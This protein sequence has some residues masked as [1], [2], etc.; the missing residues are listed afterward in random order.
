MPEGFPFPLP[1]FL[2]GGGGE[3]TPYPGLGALIDE[4]MR[5][6]AARAA[7]DQPSPAPPAPTTDIDTSPTLPAP[8]VP[9]PNIDVP[10]PPELPG[11]VID[12]EAPPPLPMTNAENYPYNIYV[13]P[14]GGTTA[15]NVPREM[16]N[17]YT[18]RWSLGAVMTPRLPRIPLP[19]EAG[20]GA[21][22]RGVPR[23][24]EGEVIPGTPRM[25]DPVTIWEDYGDI[26]GYEGFRRAFPG[27]VVRRAGRSLER[28]PFGSKRQGEIVIVGRRPP[29]PPVSIGGVPVRFPRPDVRVITNPP[30][31]PLPRAPMPTP[32]PR[33]EIPRPPQVEVPRVP[34]P[35]PFPAPVFRPAPTPAPSA[36]PLP[37]PRPTVPAPRSPRPAATPRQ[38]SNPIVRE[39]ARL[40]GAILATP[41][42][43][44]RRSALTLPRS[45]L[46]TPLPSSP[47]PSPLP[48]SPLPSPL[49]L[50][51]PLTQFNTASAGFSPPSTPTRTRT[52]ECHCDDRPKKRKKPRP[53]NARGLL[54]WASGPKKGK[55]AGSRCIRFGAKA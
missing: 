12:P 35:T 17:P 13:P 41:R 26:P 37:A 28:G 14:G 25:K 49:P 5:Q 22:P 6:R 15:R 36:P 7:A 50:P 24:I 30:P 27:E 44:G 46:V 52:R 18:P 39:L 21:V 32:P 3:G 43:S 33:V 23:P 10:I 31:L 11:D 38:A 40:A 8:A 16:D 51:Q 47:L 20:G 54:I 4:L 42:S 45:Q 55:P 19:R 29:R 1:P 9:I 34:A 48:S 2:P 53:C